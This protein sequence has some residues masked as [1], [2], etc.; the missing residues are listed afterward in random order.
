MAYKEEPMSNVHE[1]VTNKIISALEGG[2]VPWR[3]PWITVSPR[4]VNGRPY[5]GV[6]RLLLNLSEYKYPFFLT[7]KQ[8]N[9][10]GGHVKRGEKAHIAVFWKIIKAKT[11]EDDGKEVVKSIPYLRYYNVFNIDQTTVPL[12]A[13]RGFD[14]IRS[15]QECE[16]R[17][18]IQKAKKLLA[19][20]RDIPEIRFNAERACYIPA[21]DMVYL[22]H[23]NLFR[24]DEE[25]HVTQFH[26]LIHST[27]H[28]KRLNRTGIQQVNF[29]SE[30]YSR[31]ELIAEIGSCF[32]SNMCGIAGTFD[33]S[34][35]YIQ[36]WLK[37]L[38]NDPRMVVNA[39]ALA[40]KAVNFLLGQNDSHAE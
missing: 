23:R 27:G 17:E 15:D 7:M 40:E 35:A 38:K 37:V 6:N 1:N 9:E 33:N 22:P 12:S 19:S 39:A 26:E 21:L 28:A 11:K 5:T 18:P 24:S 3:K 14:Q 4:N 2:V 36:G 13:V 8:A 34:A 16:N 29:G 32:L 30:T 10:L 31:E 25:F 20:F